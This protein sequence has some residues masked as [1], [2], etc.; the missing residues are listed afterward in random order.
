M[1]DRADCQRVDGL[2]A[3]N[4]EHG[5]VSHIECEGLCYQTLVS[6]ISLIFKKACQLAGAPRTSSTGQTYVEYDVS[7]GAG[8]FHVFHFRCCLS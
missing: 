7:K 5:K 4:E 2:A 1:R 8:V 3:I 6:H